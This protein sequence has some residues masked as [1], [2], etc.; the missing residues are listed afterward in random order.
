MPGPVAVG[1]ISSVAGAVAN[2]LLGG[3]GGSSGGSGVEAARI[4]AEAA[5]NIANLTN[6]SNRLIAE[7]NNAEAQGRFDQ[8]LA[9]AEQIRRI[10]EEKDIIR[11]REAGLGSQTP[12]HRTYFD[13]AR[14]WVVE[15]EPTQ[16]HV[17]ETGQRAQGLENIVGTRERREAGERASRLGGDAE[18][19]AQVL[20]DEFAN[21]QPERPHDL[22]QLLF[23]RGEQARQGQADRIGAQV[24]TQARRVGAD[25][26]RRF[27]S[28]ARASSEDART[29]MIDAL[30][31]GGDVERSRRASQRSNIGN[32]LARATATASNIPTAGISIPSYTQPSGGLPAG[33]RADPA[34]GGAFGLP[35]PQTPYELPDFNPAVLAGL[36]ALDTSGG[37]LLGD[38]GK[39]LAPKI[40]SLIDE[41]LARYAAERSNNPYYGRSD[42]M[43]GGFRVG[44]TSSSGFDFGNR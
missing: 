9:Y 36:Q 44:S 8:A 16:R 18:I 12:T 15:E 34:A 6:E 40:P 35:I 21:V 10:E 4:A 37:G 31:R 42:Q 39:L 17:R 1:V 30:L 25:P 26:T 11:R 33:G 14:G 23:A 43:G 20:G 29:A 27:S 2:R 5:T 38:F 32:E 22:A 3:G 19:R 28:E 41:V 7:M 13:P 24:N